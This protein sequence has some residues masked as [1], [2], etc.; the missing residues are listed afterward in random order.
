[1]KNMNK[2]PWTRRAIHWTSGVMIISGA[3]LVP[4]SAASAAPE[5]S[6]QVEASAPAGAACGDPYSLWIPDDN[7]VYTY[8]GD[9]VDCAAW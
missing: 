5:T 1:M 7:G 6:T 4:I 8:S 3:V 9:Y 2:P